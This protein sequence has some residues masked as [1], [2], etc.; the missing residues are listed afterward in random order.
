MISPAFVLCDLLSRGARVMKHRV[1]K[2]R[3]SGGQILGD[4]EE[5]QDRMAFIAPSGSPAHASAFLFLADGMGGH[6]GGADAAELAM[7]AAETVAQASVEGA[8]ITLVTAMERANEAIADAKARNSD[9]RGAMGCTFIGAGLAGQRVA[10]LSVGD[11]LLLHVSRSAISR[12]NADHSMAGLLDQQAHEGE[13]SIDAARKDPRRHQLRSAL[14]GEP[15]PLIDQG[16]APVIVAP[17]DRVILASDGLLALEPGEVLKASQ[18]HS[19][20]DAL[21]A[22]L[23]K[24]VREACKNGLD[25]TTVIV[26]EFDR[27]KRLFG[28]F[29]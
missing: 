27:Q 3:I 22:Q 28:L 6:A 12:L 2:W 5:Q 10:F 4:R 14:T 7:A 20:A 24:D 11:S 17:G 18:A 26:A 21:V 29:S 1:G 9:A 16:E 23:L 19:S 13:I 8:Q 15:V 25:N